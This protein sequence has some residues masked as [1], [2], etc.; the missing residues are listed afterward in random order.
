MKGIQL[1]NINMLTKPQN[2]IIGDICECPEAELGTKKQKY[3]FI[4]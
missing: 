2:M 4:W 3:S 1:A